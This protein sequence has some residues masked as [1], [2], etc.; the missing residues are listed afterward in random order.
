MFTKYQNAELLY[1][2]RQRENDRITKIAKLV[3]Q[4]LVLV[5]DQL[6]N[7]T[8]EYINATLNRSK[9]NTYLIFS[10][11]VATLRQRQINFM[12][13]IDNI[14]HAIHKFNNKYFFNLYYVHEDDDN[15][16]RFIAIEIDK[17]KQILEEK[18]IEPF[19][20]YNNDPIDIY[21]RINE[22]EFHVQ[23]CFNNNL[24]TLIY[25]DFLYVNN[26]PTT[27][28][29]SKSLKKIIQIFNDIYQYNYKD[30][31]LHEEY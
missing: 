24:Y 3:H 17:D 19:Y 31:Y 21:I 7:A 10:L 29:S 18:D 25:D 8:K 14:N 26:K 4:E 30:N 11:P 6:I 9:L 16:H 28:F 5:N 22:I 2:N 23:L 20:E 27:K 1:N 12:D 13:I 15:I